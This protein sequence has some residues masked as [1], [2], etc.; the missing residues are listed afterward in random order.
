MTK[1][2]ITNVPDS[3]RHRLL[4]KSRETGRPYEEFLKYYAIERFLYRLGK[5]R[6]A[7]RLIL[8][9]GLT[10]RIWEGA[11]SRPTMDIDVLAQLEGGAEAVVAMVRECLRLNDTDDGLQFNEDHL[12]I[13]PIRAKK[14]I[15]GIRLLIPATL[16]TTRIQV[17]MDVGFDD[18]V[19]PPPQLLQ[20]P[21]L[22]NHPIPQLRVYPP[23]AL[24]AEKFQAIVALDT[25][26]T[27]LKDFYDIWM[28]ARRRNFQG[29]LLSQAI[30]TTFSKRNT[31]LPQEVPIGLTQ[32]F[33]DDAIKAKQWSS[34]LNQNRLP[35][36]S[37]K[38]PEVAE[39]LT[40][41]L[42]PVTR[43]AVFSHIWNFQKVVWEPITAES[44]GLKDQH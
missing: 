23:E 5:T 27:R 34:F 31:D 40:L 35:E 37:L 19:L 3:I 39:T 13:E 38:L 10:L 6:Q 12:R 20:Y 28:L 33:F 9:G 22:L 11:W 2:A 30:R 18:E 16:G 43:G 14:E 17:Q 41:F 42:L 32:I 29:D 7:E 26:N 4:N 25:A 36:T 15:P 1:K 24:I 21:T 8:K 44:P